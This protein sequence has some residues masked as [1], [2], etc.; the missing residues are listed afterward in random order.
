MANRGKERP[1]CTS[2][3][4]FKKEGRSCR[5]CNSH[6]TRPRSRGGDDGYPNE[7]ERNREEEHD[8]WHNLNVNL[9][10]GEVARLTLFDWETYNPH[11]EKRES[12]TNFERLEKRIASW[13][14]LYGEYATKRS[15]MEVII[16]KF[17]RRSYDRKHIRR[18]LEEA[19]EARKMGKRDYKHLIKLLVEKVKE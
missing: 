16:K 15:V 7:V 19:L 10:V 4:G 6:H 14:V 11:L 2:C 3:G 8:P 1:R 18:V 13:D 17:T 9:R 5:K 12:F